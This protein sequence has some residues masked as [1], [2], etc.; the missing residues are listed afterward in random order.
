MNAENKEKNTP[1]HQACARGHTEVAKQLV[2]LGASLNAA[3]TK[4][5]TPFHNA[6]SH[7]K[8]ELLKN[9]TV[10]ERSNVYYFTERYSYMI[11]V[12]NRVIIFIIF[13]GSWGFYRG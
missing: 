11:I 13:N 4:G 12:R 2:T 9:P 6:I 1:L 10:V 7:A 8:D 3:N 5:Y